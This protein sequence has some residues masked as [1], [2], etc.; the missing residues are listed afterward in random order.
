ML[1]LISL[2]ITPCSHLREPSANFGKS[3][4]WTSTFPGPMYTTPRL[5]AIHFL[6]LEKLEHH[7]ASFRHRVIL[8]T[9]AAAN[10]HCADDLSTAFQG[11]AAGEERN[12]PAITRKA[13]VDGR[14]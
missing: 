5:F 10:S 6:Q 12:S 2:R 1:V 4:D 3:I 11:Y 7:R 14:C 13:R 8:F 9:R